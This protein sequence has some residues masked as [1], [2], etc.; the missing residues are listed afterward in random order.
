MSYPKI[1]LTILFFALIALGFSYYAQYGLNLAPCPLCLTQRAL[2]FALGAL[3]FIAL[4][5][6]W[7][8]RLLRLTQVNLLALLLMGAYHTYV[9]YRQTLCGC[10]D[11]S[12]SLFGLPAPLYSAILCLALLI[13]T[14]FFLL[15]KKN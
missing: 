13:T 12:W 15:R 2:Y 4:F 14:Q 7:K 10:S 3:A 11:T 9:E 1:F 6:P 5:V 8:R